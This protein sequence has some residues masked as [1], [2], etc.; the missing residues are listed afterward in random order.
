MRFPSVCAVRRSL[1]SRICLCLTAAIGFLVSARPATAD[2]ITV[3]LGAGQTSIGSDPYDVISESG[4]NLQLDLAL[5]IP[6]TQTFYTA[7]YSANCTGCSVGSVNFT[8]F[9]YVSD[10]SPFGSGSGLFV[11]T[12][13]DTVNSNVH[14]FTP[15]TI[16]PTTISLNNGRSLTITPQ[17]G[18]P[19]TLATGRS[20]SSPI[21]ATFLLTS[22][23]S[24]VPEPSSFALLGSGLLGVAGVVRRRTL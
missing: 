10:Q 18:V 22:S 15:T 2:T 9:V 6:V 14:T 3:Q 8:T 23:A 7:L 21:S 13:N 20:G 11:Q 5:G 1:N 16:F 17:T 4:S 24:P 12:F 19:T